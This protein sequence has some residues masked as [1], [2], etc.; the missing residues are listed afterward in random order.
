MEFNQ[1]IIDQEQILL[2]SLQM[3]EIFNFEYRTL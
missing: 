2:K 1:V 3:T